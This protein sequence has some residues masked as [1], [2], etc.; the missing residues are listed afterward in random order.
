MPRI[1]ANQTQSMLKTLMGCLQLQESLAEAATHELLRLLA[2]E[3]DSLFGA[4][5]RARHNV[6]VVVIRPTSGKGRTSS[7]LS[8]A[9]S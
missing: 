2:V 6:D 4:V 7:S 5:R 9:T 1:L 3:I 8:V